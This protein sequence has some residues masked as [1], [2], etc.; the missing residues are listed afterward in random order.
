M[1]ATPDQTRDAATHTAPADAPDP[2]DF[3][4]RAH[5]LVLDILKANIP[6]AALAAHYNVPFLTLVDYV[7]T[8]EVQAEIDAYEK[9]TNLRARLLGQTARPVS[10]RKLLDVL[11]SPAPEPRG[12]DP[13]ADQRALHRHAELIRR[14][15][16]TI[17]KEARA[18]APKSALAPKPAPKPASKS[19]VPPES[20]ADQHTQAGA[21]SAP[22]QSSSAGS[23][24]SSSTSSSSSASSPAPD[25]PAQEIIAPDMTPDSCPSSTSSPSPSDL[26]DLRDLRVQEPSPPRSSASSAFNNSASS[27]RHARDRPAA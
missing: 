7:N 18:L 10:I 17:A 6:L 15:A 23:S 27:S 20:R 22:M 21:P 8:P 26:R 2:I 4:L 24:S 13:E 25:Q 14:T 19:D 5:H 3:A 11:Q 9:L 16:T 1:I 12:R